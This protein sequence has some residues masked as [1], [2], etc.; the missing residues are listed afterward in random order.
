MIQARQT[1]AHSGNE[2]PNLHRHGPESNVSGNC[3]NRRLTTFLN[4]VW[5]MGIKDVAAVAQCTHLQFAGC[6][7]QKA[8]IAWEFLSLAQE[9][10]ASRVFRASAL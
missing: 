7:G 9:P 10:D 1:D 5:N 2:K 6:L 3:L 8:A 4:S